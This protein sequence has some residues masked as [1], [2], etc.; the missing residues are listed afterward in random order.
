M[1]WNALLINDG[2]KLAG[3]AC[4]L[5]IMETE[6]ERYASGL[7]SQYIQVP[8]SGRGDA[9]TPIFTFLEEALEKAHALFTTIL[10]RGDMFPNWVITASWGWTD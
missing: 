1:L 6:K 5:K 3:C 2:R 7:W 8:A 4:F 10:F 9:T